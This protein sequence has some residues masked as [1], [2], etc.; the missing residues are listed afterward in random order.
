MPH[1]LITLKVI[2]RIATVTLNAPP[3]NLLN[4]AM[5]KEL[6]QVFGELEADHAVRVV[7]L[8]ASGRFFCLGADIKELAGLEAAH[9]GADLSGR[10]QGLLNRIERFDKP[11]IA[12]INGTCLGGGLELAMA[13]HMRVAAE[14]IQLGLPEVKLGLIPGFGG[15]QRLQRIIGPSRAAEMIL[16]GE[17]I[18]AE[19]A[20]SIG[21]VNRVV[22]AQEVLPQSQT[23]ASMITNKGRLATRA[24]LRG[25]RNGLDSPFAEGLAH[26]SE[27]FGELCETTDKKE[28][29][30]AFLEKRPPKFSDH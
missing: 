7:I 9:Q 4:T 24:A 5:L 11:I 13:C 3:S 23:L 28:G 18:D 2:D 27:L 17:P 8:T 14:G 25:I 15:T 30:A 20:L 26:E 21:L 10:G 16:T 19:H 1:K 22:P 29:T 6:D 12:A